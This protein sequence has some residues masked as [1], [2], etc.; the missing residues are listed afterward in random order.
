MSLA[1]RLAFAVL[2]AVPKSAHAIARA[3]LH[4]AINKGCAASRRT[5]DASCCE[6]KAGA[7]RA[8][9]SDRFAALHEKLSRGN[10]TTITVGLVGDSTSTVVTPALVEVLQSVAAPGTAFKLQQERRRG[11]AKGALNGLLDCSLES[12]SSADLV[13][14]QIAY[15]QGRPVGKTA[16]ILDRTFEQN[17]RALLGLPKRPLLLFI[18]H[19]VARDFLD[20]APRAGLARTATL[21]RYWDDARKKWREPTDWSLVPAGW[22][23][24]AREYEEE[25]AAQYGLPFVSTCNAARAMLA[26]APSACA[27]NASASGA[28]FASL[29]ALISKLMPD[30][31]HLSQEGKDVQT[32]LASHALLQ[33]AKP[34]AP[35]VAADH[36]A[37]TH[38]HALPVPLP[39]P[40]GDAVRAAHM[41]S[42]SAVDK[43]REPLWRNASQ[44]EASVAE[45][46][47]WCREDANALLGDA[48]GSS[49]WALRS[50]SGDGSKQWL[51]AETT[52]AW[53]EWR[54]PQPATHYYL[55][56]YR[57]DTLALGRVDITVDGEHAH[58]DLDLC[59]PPH[60]CEAAPAGQ[61]IYEQVRVPPAPRM[62][63]AAV[64]TLRLQVASPRTASWLEWLSS[65]NRLLSQCQRA[66]LNQAGAVSLVGLRA[67][68]AA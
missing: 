59:C 68:Q 10:G 8:A 4:D 61:G 63:P 18:S 47:T 19:C 52:G 16:H 21:Q 1:L 7:W 22:F 36:H 66:A 49:G 29:P 39:P 48:R 64:H 44:Y 53:I 5:C 13:V 24:A 32:C 25:L 55:T 38:A 15:A 65:S 26:T 28:P 46:P 35:H 37:G 40:L 62:L 17:L 30:F 50:G 45:Q 67:M 60:G 14:L 33:S 54:L 57:H 27:N 31:M 3:A 34:D 9:G 51:A 23:A 2:A 20:D 6:H 42:H 56:L 43:V 11:F 41:F 58:K 12:L